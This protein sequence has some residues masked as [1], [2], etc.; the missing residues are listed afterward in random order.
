MYAVIETGGK[1]YRVELG[2]ELAVERLDAAPGATVEFERVLLV[3]D[4][5]AAQ[6]GTPIVADALVTGEVVRQDRGEKV[7][8]FK[9]RPKARHRAKKG[10]R[11]EQTVVRVADI[12]FNGRSAAEEAGTQEKQEAKARK[13]AVAEAE[14]KAAADQELAAKLAKDEAARE[15]KDEAAARGQDRAAAKRQAGR[16]PRL[17]RKP[18]P[19]PA[20]KSTT[21]NEGINGQRQRKARNEGSTPSAA[22]KTHDAPHKHQEGRVNEMAHKKAGSSSKNGRDSV[23]QRLGVKAGDGQLVS[24]G[25]II[26]RQRGMTFLAGP[27]TDLGKDYTL[28]ATVDGR[29]RFEHERRDKK[30]VRV[31]AEIAPS[32]AEAAGSNA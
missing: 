10:H 6:I 7:I 22:K 19:A 4:G 32:T 13:A 15:A 1:Q 5:D 14:K 11:Q 12:R 27:G 30:R 16:S 8:V 23:G 20:T 24:A 9:Y 2:S 18:K 28:F 26:V 29:V 21:V 17:P 31:E 25:S 3:A